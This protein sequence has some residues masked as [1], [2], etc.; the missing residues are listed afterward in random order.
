M[1]KQEARATMDDPQ[2]EAHITMRA[3]VRATVRKVVD[4][5]GRPVNLANATM[6]PAPGWQWR[7]ENGCWYHEPNSTTGEG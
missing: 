4:A 3:P 6:I 2:A 5:K 1:G 7:F